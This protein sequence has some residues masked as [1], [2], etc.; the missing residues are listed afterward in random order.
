MQAINHVH[1]YFESAHASLP[2]ILSNH[3]ERLHSLSTLSATSRIMIFHPPASYLFWYGRSIHSISLYPRL[4]TLSQC[5]GHSSAFNFLRGGVDWVW[6]A[7]GKWRLHARAKIIEK[8]M[9]KMLNGKLYVLGGLYGVAVSVSMTEIQWLP[10]RLLTNELRV[11]LWERGEFM[12]LSHIMCILYCVPLTLVQ[13][14]NVEHG[15]ELCIRAK[16]NIIPVEFFSSWPHTKLSEFCAICGHLW[17]IPQI[18][19][20]STKCTFSMSK[21]TTPLIRELY[22]G[23][24]E[25][26]RSHRGRWNWPCFSW[27]CH[28][29]TYWTAFIFLGSH[30]TFL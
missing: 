15:N 9:R 2:R 20:I 26:R 12:G 1:Q 8:Q 6:M 18:P 24:P 3:G 10:S 27:F 30:S 11:P 29:E 19:Q 13:A 5:V 23:C 21:N 22:G 16:K 28:D 7:W 17:Q 4:S 14:A 25:R